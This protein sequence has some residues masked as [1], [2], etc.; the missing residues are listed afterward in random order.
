[1]TTAKEISVDVAVVAVL[2]EPDNIFKLYV[3][4]NSVEGFS[5]YTTFFHFTPDSL[6][7][8]FHFNT[9]LHSS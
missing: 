1:M 8:E 9:M 2:S 6:W 7:K 5:Q 3:Y 4:L